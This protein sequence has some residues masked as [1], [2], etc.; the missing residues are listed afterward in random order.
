MSPEQKKK[1]SPGNV[2]LLCGKT[3]LLN[4]HCFKEGLRLCHVIGEMVFY[5]QFG[6]TCS[7]LFP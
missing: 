1:N 6:I 4:W 2:W 3:L 7:R 5:D